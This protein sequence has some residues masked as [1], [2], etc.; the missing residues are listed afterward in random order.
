MVLEVSLTADE[1]LA[2][3]LRQLAKPTCV[4][5]DCT[6]NVS[7]RCNIRYRALSRPFHQCHMAINHL[8]Y[9]D[10]RDNGIMQQ[11]RIRKMGHTYWVV[12]ELC[13][14]SRACLVCTML[15]CQQS[16]W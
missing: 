15:D 16:M 10:R 7:R 13:Q 9:V 1:F 14:M 4:C 8:A 2:G 12:V 3:L 11:E 6:R 5:I